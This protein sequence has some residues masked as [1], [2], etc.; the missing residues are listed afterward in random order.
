MLLVIA[1]SLAL[2]G[3]AAITRDLRHPGGY[4]GRLLDKRTFDASESKQVQ[5]FRF[6]LVL[7]MAARMAGETVRTSDQADAVAK[8]LSATALEINHTAANLYAID[9]RPPCSVGQSRIDIPPKTD[10]Q[11]L[12][13]IEAKLNQAV[14]KAQTAASDAE[15]AKAASEKIEGRIRDLLKGMPAA[16]IPATAPRTDPPCNGYYTNFEADVPLIEY[17]MISLVLAVLPRDQIK[18]FAKDLEKGN[19]LGGSF[20]LLKVIFIGVKGLHTAAATYRTGQEALVANGAQCNELRLEN[21]ATVKDA[22]RCLGLDPATLFGPHPNELTGEKLPYTITEDAFKAL[23][24][25]TRSSC[26]R[27]PIGSGDNTG[28][29]VQKLREYRRDLCNNLYWRPTRRRDVID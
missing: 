9:G 17:P 10:E 14:G 13:E 28:P 2:Q 8:H 23:M 4:P 21:A 29:E 26:V 22:V 19:F 18:Q 3:C 15:T 7:A 6:A 20:S 24:F 1:S 27:M 5:L 11:K 12:R 25:V 16:A